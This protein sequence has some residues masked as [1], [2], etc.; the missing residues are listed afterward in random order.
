MYP[1]QQ[2]CTLESTVKE[3]IG[4]LSPEESATLVKARTIMI[5]VVVQFLKSL[6]WP[7]KDLTSNTSRETSWLPSRG[8]EI[9][10]GFVLGYLLGMSEN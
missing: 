4:F 6:E 7:E 1:H 3:F 9:P 2:S 5:N 10:G 8:H